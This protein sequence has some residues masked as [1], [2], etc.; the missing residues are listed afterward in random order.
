MKTKFLM[1]GLILVLSAGLLAL[2]AGMAGLGPFGKYVA[3]NKNSAAAS[4]SGADDSLRSIVKSLNLSGVGV[5]DFEVKD[6]LNMG[7][8][9]VLFVDNQW[10]QS[11][12]ENSTLMSWLGSSIMSGTPTVVFGQNVDPSVLYEF[13]PTSLKSQCQHSPQPFIGQG[14]CLRGFAHWVSIG[15]TELSPEDVTD[16]YNWATSYL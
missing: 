6:P 14:V 11:E 10:L 4:L 5:L 15:G 7:S 2:G 13:V 3:F 16:G 1:I 12:R 8:Y 9:Q